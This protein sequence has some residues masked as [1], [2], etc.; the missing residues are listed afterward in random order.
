[1]GRYRGG[2]A[3]GFRARTAVYFRVCVAEFNRDVSDALGAVPLCFHS[4]YGKHECGF[5]MGHMS[6]R[7]YVD[8]SLTGNHFVGGWGQGGDI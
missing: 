1:M 2:V 8:C 4:G 7:S 6:D 5:A 3:V